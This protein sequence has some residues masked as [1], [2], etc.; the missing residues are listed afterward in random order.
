MIVP[1]R[2]A[3][4]TVAADRDAAAVAARQLRGPRNWALVAAAAAVAALVAAAVAARVVAAAAAAVAALVAA[5]LQRY[6]SNCEGP[7]IGMGGTNGTMACACCV[8]NVLGFHCM[9]HHSHDRRYNL[10]VR[11]GSGM[12]WLCMSW[13][14]R[15]S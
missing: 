1:M 14:G 10:Q 6:H 13:L 9:E 7:V 2:M 8:R 5:P 12:S 4:P 15:S 3:G 11:Q